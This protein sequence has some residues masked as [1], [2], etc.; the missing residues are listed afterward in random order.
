MCYVPH[1]EFLGRLCECEIREA[2]DSVRDGNMDTFYLVALE[3][4]CY[5]AF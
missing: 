1:D 5:A 2:A 4:D 3:V